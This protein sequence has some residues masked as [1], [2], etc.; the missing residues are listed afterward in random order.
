M[1]VKYTVKTIDTPQHDR[2]ESRQQYRDILGRQEWWDERPDMIDPCTEKF[3]EEFTEYLGTHIRESGTFGTGVRG[4]VLLKFLTELANGPFIDT[5]GDDATG[6]LVN[7]PLAD[8]AEDAAKRIIAQKILLHVTAP[9]DLTEEEN[10]AY[11][12]AL[13]I[14][15]WHVNNPCVELKALEE[16]ARLNVFET[17]LPQG[18]RQYR[19]PLHWVG[20]RTPDNELYKMISNHFNRPLVLAA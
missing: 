11:D 9:Y 10:V 6:L 15:A 16:Q 20:G 5:T 4:K 8:T 7:E 3:C 14:L 17:C 12:I 13:D 1:H 19:K 18:E 2:H